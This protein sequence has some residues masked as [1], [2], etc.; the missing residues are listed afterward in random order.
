MGAEE[1]VV[2]DLAELSYI[3]APGLS[4]LAVEKRQ[5][6]ISGLALRISSPPAF[7]RQ[8]LD[9]TGLIDFL[10]VTPES[11]RVNGSGMARLS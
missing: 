6:D 4:V 8:L 10:D 3:D 9:I 1:P 5:A 7:V 2:L 11:D